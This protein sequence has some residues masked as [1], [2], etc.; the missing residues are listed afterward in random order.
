[1]DD[2]QN[3]HQPCGITDSRPTIKE[4]KKPGLKRAASTDLHKALIICVRVC[5]MENPFEF[6]GFFNTG[7]DRYPLDR[8]TRSVVDKNQNIFSV[9]NQF[10]LEA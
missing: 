8:K 5:T 6:D 10:F 2:T 7:K 1:M 4:R 9:K 3:R